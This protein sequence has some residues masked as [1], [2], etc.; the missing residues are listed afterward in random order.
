MSFDFSEVWERDGFGSLVCFDGMINALRA[1]FILPLLD[2]GLFAH[3]TNA[4]CVS[5]E[6]HAGKSLT[7]DFAKFGLVVVMV[8]RTYEDVGHPALSDIGEGAFGWFH[9]HGLRRVK[10]VHLARQ[11]V[12]QGFA[13][14]EPQSSVGF[15][16]EKRRPRFAGELNEIAW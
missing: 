9:R 14:A 15:T 3:H 7:V 10:G 6:W 2:D 8:G 16:A 11:G 5:V 12:S 1:L 13:L 4:R